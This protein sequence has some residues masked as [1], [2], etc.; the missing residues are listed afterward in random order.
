MLNTLVS[1]KPGKVFQQLDA[2]PSLTEDVTRCAVSLRNKSTDPAPAGCATVTPHATDLSP[3]CL[4]A[5]GNTAIVMFVDSLLALTT[6]LAA[7]KTSI[8]FL[9]MM[10]RRAGI[11]L[12]GLPLEFCQSS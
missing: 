6:H 4:P 5:S 10:L 7:C 11:K 8:D 9:P 12:H 3:S 1:E 2:S